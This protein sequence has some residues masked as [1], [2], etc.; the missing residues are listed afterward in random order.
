MNN[1]W[2]TA[3]QRL[4]ILVSAI[5]LLLPLVLSASPVTSEIFA[6]IM[7]YTIGAVFLLSFPTSLCA[8]P[9]LALFKFIL[10][11][12][13]DTMFTAYFYLVLLNLIGYVQWFRVMPAFLGNSKPMTLPTILE[14]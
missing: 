4:W 2:G 5:S 11:M 14:N 1:N 3:L 10:E 7:A 6:A 13:A 12:E 9:F 8:L